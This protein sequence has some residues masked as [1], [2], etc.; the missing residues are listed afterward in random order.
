MKDRNI[1]IWPD[2]DPDGRAAADQAA[3]L[4]LAAG[5]TTVSVV[6][7]PKDL[8]R[9]WDLA[10]IVP[11]GIDIAMLLDSAKPVTMTCTT[12]GRATESSRP[13]FRPCAPGEPFPLEALGPTLMPV[14]KAI[15]DLTQA[16]AA[17]CGN[18]VLAAA[19]LAVQARWDVW[20]P[21]G[22]VRPISLML[23]TVAASG[24][25]KTSADREALRGVR[26]RE[27]ELRQAFPEVQAQHR[28]A[29]DAYQAVRA[30]IIKAHKD[31]MGAIRA[32]LDELGPEPVRPKQPILVVSEP[33]IE[34]LIKLL[35]D[36]LPT[37]GLFSSE[38]GSFLGGHAMS[39]EAKLRSAARLSS[40]WDGE[41]IDRIRAGEAA[42]VLVGR[43]L[44]LHLMAQPEAAAIFLN[45]PVLRDQGLLSR[46]LIAAPEPRAGTRLFREASDASRIRVAEFGSHILGLLRDL[47]ENQDPLPRLQLNSEAQKLFIRGHDEVERAIPTRFNHVRGFAAKLPEHA[48]G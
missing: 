7:L 1:V 31:N 9:G 36:A 41:P 13:L 33:T 32:A 15:E 43:R 29:Q 19:C 40:L 28:N 44:A 45:D 23:M 18:A 21:S 47:S 27:R 17:I 48:G 35:A 5:A 4:M 6:P 34:G 26:D 37:I 3:T 25:R 24:E 46:L 16:P 30:R 39:E 22:Q 38:G 14:A 8:T 12:E 20:L 10:D 42:N 11:E 2:A